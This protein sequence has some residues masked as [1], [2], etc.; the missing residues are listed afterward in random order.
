VSLQDEL[1]A[2][3]IQWEVRSDPEV[4]PNTPLISSGV[5][6]SAALF[7]LLHWIEE[8]IGAPVDPTA[9]DLVAEWDTVGDVARFVEARRAA[10]GKD[11]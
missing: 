9:F 11:R 10:R 4:T 8:R 1:L 3:L 5:L 2:Q 7:N 6:D